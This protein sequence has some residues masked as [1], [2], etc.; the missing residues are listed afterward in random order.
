MEHIRTLLGDFSA[1]HRLRGALAVADVV[2]RAGAIVAPYGAIHSYRRQII[3]LAASDHVKAHLAREQ[4]P[5][6]LNAINKECGE[7]TVKTLR[8]IVGE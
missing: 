2:A 4:E 1:R 7:N 6:L 5:E 3:T 8:I